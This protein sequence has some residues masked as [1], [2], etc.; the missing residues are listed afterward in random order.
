MKQS[1]YVLPVDFLWL[2]LNV[3]PLFSTCHIQEENGI[4]IN[5]NGLSGFITSA[6]FCSILFIFNCYV[7]EDKRPVDKNCIY[8]NF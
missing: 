5:I 6:Y 8:H 1:L 2:P 3:L 4:I 7:F